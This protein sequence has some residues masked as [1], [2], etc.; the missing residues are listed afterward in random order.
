MCFP[1]NSSF[2][3]WEL[4]MNLPSNGSARWPSTFRKVRIVSVP[5]VHTLQKA[6]L[7]SG[8]LV[9][10]LTESGAR[11]LCAKWQSDPPLLP[12]PGTAR[13]TH[14]A[15]RLSFPWWLSLWGL[16]R[17]FTVGTVR[18][19][20]YWN[21]GVKHGHFYF[22]LIAL[23]SHS[24]INKVHYWQTI[25]SVFLLDFRCF[26]LFFILNKTKSLQPI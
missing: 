25:C 21:A 13:L 12:T 2:I 10:F 4:L 6:C 15:E 8:I 7:P 3:S 16:H 5:S 11:P 1:V 9:L 17:A 24:L 18:I 23:L 19:I 14:Q 20:T 26:F 22:Q